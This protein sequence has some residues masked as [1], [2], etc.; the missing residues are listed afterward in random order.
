MSNSIAVS[1]GTT[2][3][4]ILLFLLAAVAL[5]VWVIVRVIRPAVGDTKMCPHCAETIKAEAKVCR[6]CGRDV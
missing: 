4:L 1:I 6:F 2:E 5:I 3:I